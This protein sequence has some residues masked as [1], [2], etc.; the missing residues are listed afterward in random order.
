MTGIVVRLSSR[1]PVSSVDVQ[2]AFTAIYCDFV[3]RCVP[4]PPLQAH[5]VIDVT[6]LACPEGAPPLC[7]TSPTFDSRFIRIPEFAQ[8]RWSPLSRRH[9]RVRG[10][11]YMVTTVRRRRG[12]PPKAALQCLI[13]ACWEY[14]FEK[15]DKAGFKIRNGAG[16]YKTMYYLTETFPNCK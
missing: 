14:R 11:S 8:W 5:V 10:R 7:W 3:L 12:R 1:C 15:E 2:A 13:P 16:D 9:W 4:P 6:L